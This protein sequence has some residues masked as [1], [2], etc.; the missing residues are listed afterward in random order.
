MKH[1]K[2][3]L[4]F[5]FAWAAFFGGILFEHFK[6]PAVAQTQ[7]KTAAQTFKNIKVFKDLPA[8]QL[9]GVMNFMAG[10]L[11]VSCNHCHVPNQFSKDD[12]PAK[13]IAREH[14]EMMRAVNDANFGGKTIVNCATCHRGETRPAS[15][16]SLAKNPSPSE[17]EVPSSQSLPTVDQILDKYIHAVGGRK[18][19]ET[20]KT[21]TITGTREMRNGMDASQVEQMETYRKS[22]GKLLMNFKAGENSSSQAFDGA[23]GWRKFNGRVSAISGADLLGAK[24]DADFY[25]DIYF[26]EQYPK[27]SVVGLQK[28]NGR[29][30]FVIEATFAETHPARAMFGIQ[31]EKLYFDT[32]SRL[33]IRR[34]MEYRTALGGL[35]EVTDYADYRKI[36]GVLF[37]F[38]IRLSRPPLTVTQKFSEIKINAPIE[39]KLFEM[40]ATK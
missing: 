15:V 38:T 23:T 13:Q 27:L 20:L 18:K 4:C 29:D 10:S 21:L 30:A 34:S 9:L 17:I 37:P 40:P 39:D 35:P 11:G 19:I 8:S 12:K 3:T 33:L 28:I 16:L 2:I 26:K 25:K 24:R 6:S 36:K 22:T 14:I 7:E 5:V 1:L 31:N 32:Q